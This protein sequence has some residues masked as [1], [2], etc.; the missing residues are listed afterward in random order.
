MLNKASSIFGD[1]NFFYSYIIQL[2]IKKPFLYSGPDLR[3]GK[4]D[5]CPGEQNLGIFY[6]TKHLMIVTTIKGA[7]L[8]LKKKK[9]NI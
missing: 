9:L 8:G 6:R 1:N 4:G 7:N 3:G 5:I 2:F